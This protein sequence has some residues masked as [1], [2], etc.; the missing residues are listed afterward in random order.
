MERKD[1]KLLVSLKEKLPE[2]EKLLEKVSS[3]WHYEDMVYRF[4]HQ[5]FKVYRVQ[6]DT[7]CIVE[8]LQSLAPD[9]KLN[10]RFLEILADGLNKNFEHSHNNNWGKHT[11]PLLEAFF[12]AKYFLEQAVKYGKELE[13][14]PDLLPSGWAGFLYLFDMR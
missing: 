14:A 7:Q 4:Y 3:E 10:K 9:T 2:L 1:E 11:R 6:N 13:K 12:H 5:S 8:V